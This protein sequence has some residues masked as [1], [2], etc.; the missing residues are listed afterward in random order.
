MH[1]QYVPNFV[2][3]AVVLIREKDSVLMVQ[4]N[5]G[6]HLWGIPGGLMENHETIEQAAIR[7]AREETGLTIRVKRPITFYSIPKQ[8]ALTVSFECEITGGT[9]LQETDETSGCKFFP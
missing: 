2:V 1:I 4:Q 9:M 5:I 7:E 8:T 6:N 3:A